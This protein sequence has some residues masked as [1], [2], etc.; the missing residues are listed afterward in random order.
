MM[1]IMNGAKNKKKYFKFDS[2]KIKMIKKNAPIV[3]KI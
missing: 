3:K 1:K 2:I